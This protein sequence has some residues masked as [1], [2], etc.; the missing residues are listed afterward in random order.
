M[1]TANLFI[2]RMKMRGIYDIRKRL[3]GHL[4]CIVRNLLASDK[5]SISEIA[6]FA[7][8]SEAFVRNVKKESK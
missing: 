7:S 6:N 5:F 3:N 8:V 2:S 1:D 4:G